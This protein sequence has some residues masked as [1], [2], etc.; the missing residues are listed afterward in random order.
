MNKYSAVA[1]LVLGGLLACGTLATAQEAKGGKDKGGKRGPGVEQLLERMTTDLKLTDAQKPKVKAALEENMKQ[2]Q[3]LR[4]VPQD[5][6]REKMSALMEEQK[7]KMKAILTPEQ[8]EKWQKQ[9]EAMRGN[10]PGGPGAPG[11]E[12]KSEAQKTE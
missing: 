8:F 3:A 9:H 7:K 4:D 6:R 5:Q 2:R 11:G 12:K 1:M 10:R